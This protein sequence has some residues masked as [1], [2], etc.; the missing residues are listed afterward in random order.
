MRALLIYPEFPDT[1]WSFRYALK[2]INRKASSP[3]LGLLTIAAMLPETWEKRLVDMNV[4]S[5]HNDHLRWADLVFISAMSVQKE[6]VKGVIARCRSAGVRIVAGGPLFTTEYEAFEEVDHLVLNEAEITLPRFLEDFNSGAGGHLYATDEWADIRKT[7]VPMWRLINIKRYA[8]INIQYSRGCPFNC[9]FCDIT[10]LCGRA[11][12]T[13]DKEQVMKELDSVYEYGFRGQVFFVDD[14]FIGN[15]KKLREEVLPGIIRWMERKKH[16]FSF[17]T[18]A[19]IELSDHEDLMQMMVRAGFDVVFVGIETPHEQSLAECSKFHNRNRDLLASVRKIQKA[20]LEV[21]G[22]FIVGFDHDPVTIFD[23]QIRFIQASGVVT[24]MVG[25]LIAL[26]RTQL[27]ERLQKEQRL[28]KETSGNN[29]DFSTNFI[30]KMDYDLLIS[31][32]KRVL[33]TLYSPKYYYQRIETFLRE[34]IPP[35]KKKKAFWFRPNYLAA[36]VRSTIVL[37]VI[38][39]ERFHYWRLLFWT[40]FRRPRLFSQAVTLSIYGFHFRRVFEERIGNTDI[41]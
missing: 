20:G 10:L 17:N 35:E 31:G 12:R 5:L 18:Q 33:G 14:N 8:S 34:Y 37:G 1:F 39:K 7:P 19:S 40:I 29:T 41:L 32:Y 38:G 30:P 4:E 9:E 25:V 23:T 15:K 2:F 28:L 3:P 21:Q 22:G 26:P 16:P 6:S 27:Y 24:A 36:F 13:K 11:P